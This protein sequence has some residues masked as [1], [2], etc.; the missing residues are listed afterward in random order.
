MPC[1]KRFGQREPVA[2]RRVLA[3]LQSVGH[4]AGKH[5]GGQCNSLC[6]ARQR[7]CRKIKA[8]CKAADGTQ[9]FRKILLQQQNLIRFI[10]PESQPIRRKHFPVIFLGAIDIGAVKVAHPVLRRGKRE[11]I[12]RKPH[13]GFVTKPVVFFVYAQIGMRIFRQMRICLD[14]YIFLTGR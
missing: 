12:L 11:T 9:R 4:I 6:A 3:A 13:I 5:I 10:D 1:G 2:I 8:V 7:T 14:T